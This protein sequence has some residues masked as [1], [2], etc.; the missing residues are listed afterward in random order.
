MS[1]LGENKRYQ[2]LISDRERLVINGVIN[3]EGFGEEFL[4]LNTSLG[5]LT[6]EGCELKI[7]S[8]TKENGEI[9][10]TGKINGVF[11]K[12][13]KSEKGFLRKIFK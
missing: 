13:E 3:V 2:L 6:V 1:D 9:L 8:L 11:Y 4:I 5:E 12:D 10:I 7:E